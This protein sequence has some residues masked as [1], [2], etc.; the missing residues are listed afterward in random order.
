[1]DATDFDQVWLSAIIESGQKHRNLLPDKDER[2]FMPAGESPD[3]AVYSIRPVAVVSVHGA[4]GYTDEVVVLLVEV[5]GFHDTPN[6]LAVNKLFE[7]VWCVHGDLGYRHLARIPR[8]SY[9]PRLL[10]PRD[11]ALEI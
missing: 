10:M 3:R 2:V 8:F 9:F 5:D 6:G 11:V 7:R 4:G 1:M